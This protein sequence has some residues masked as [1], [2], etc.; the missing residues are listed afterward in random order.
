MNLPQVCYN[1]TSL[2]KKINVELPYNPVILLLGIYPGELK[3]YSHKDL[4]INVHIS[5]NWK[6]PKYLSTTEWINILVHPYNR[7]FLCH[8]SEVTLDIQNSIDGY[9]LK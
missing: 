9:I 5:P 8:K 2:K 3:T 1:V 6:Q 4:Y 7:V